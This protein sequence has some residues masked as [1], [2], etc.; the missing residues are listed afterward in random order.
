MQSRTRIA[1]ASALSLL[2]TAPCL[3]QDGQDM[4]GMRP[5]VW[6]LQAVLASARWRAFADKVDQAYIVP[7]PATKLAQRCTD[8]L[9]QRPV[10]VDE[11][12][13][14]FCIDAVLSSLDK[15]SS[16]VSPEARAASEAS[17]PSN[18]VGI[19]LEIGGKAIGQPLPVVG[20]IAGSPGD[21]AGIRPKDAL[22]SVDGIDLRPLSIEA[23]VRALRGAEG[24]VAQVSLR[25]E[26]VAEPIALSIVRAPV[27]IMAA[28]GKMLPDGMAYVRIT[29]QNKGV[30]ADLVAV[31]QALHGPQGEVPTS[32]VVDL[33]GNE[34]GL[35][36]EVPGLAS[37][38]AAPGLPVLATAGR[39]GRTVMRTQAR[40]ASGIAWAQTVPIAVLMDG[41]TG[42]G[43]EALAQFLREARKATLVGE[44]SQGAD[45]I[46]TYLNIDAQSAMLLVSATMSSG[47]GRS[48]ADGLEP[49][50]ALAHAPRRVAY[51]DLQDAALRSAIGQLRGDQH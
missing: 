23:C 25:R 22:L 29:R 14:G 7:V 44:R 43:T 49:D 3:A 34:G 35:L 32:L 12:G 6:S 28:R 42:S 50:V 48:W 47:Q 8:A 46:R 24:S 33:R 51:D 2:L 1:T 31:L 41:R 40:P 16:Y 30:T 5:R 17:A 26:G 15:A 21:K 11:D 9:S 13:P 45:L 37:V 38:L 4:D 39:T 10:A 27:R 36:D 19:G 20:P 18:W